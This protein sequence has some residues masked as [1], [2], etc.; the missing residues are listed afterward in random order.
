MTRQ[1]IYSCCKVAPSGVLLI[2]ILSLECLEAYLIHEFWAYHWICNRLEFAKS[3]NKD[4]F[5][6]RD[7]LVNSIALTPYCP[8]VRSNI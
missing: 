4:P 8:I 3:Y 6:L 5:Q 1:A 2:S 7:C